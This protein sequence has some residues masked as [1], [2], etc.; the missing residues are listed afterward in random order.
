MKEPSFGGGFFSS[1]KSSES[2][3]EEMG[4][5]STTA[6]Q[7][8]DIC[9]YPVVDKNLFLVVIFGHGQSLESVLLCS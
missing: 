6:G 9:S 4:P 2:Q 5:F 1:P 8:T 7:L 3:P